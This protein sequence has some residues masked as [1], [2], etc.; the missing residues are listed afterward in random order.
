MG[1]DQALWR[2]SDCG[3][4]DLTAIR[5]VGARQGVTRKIVARCTLCGKPV[6][7]EI[8]RLA[9]EQRAGREK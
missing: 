4:E 6:M 5:A 8:L 9:I 1:T 2:V 7:T 3:L